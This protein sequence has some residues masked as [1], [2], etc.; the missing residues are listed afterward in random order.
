M[1]LLG[2]GAAAGHGVLSHDLALSGNLARMLS[3][4]MGRGV[5]IDVV[6]DIHLT[7]GSA[8]PA[9]QQIKLSRYDGIVLL[10]G[11]N[12]AMNLVSLRSWRRDMNALLSHLEH[13]GPVGL[14]VFV[15]TVPPLPRLR[16]M[17][18]LP[19]WL[20]NRHARRLND[21][22]ESICR[23]RPTTTLVQFRPTTT[24][25]PGRHRSPDTYR[26]WAREL[27]DPIAKVLIGAPGASYSEGVDEEARQRSLDRLGILDTAPEERFDRIAGL[28]QQLFGTASAAVTFIDGD[29]QWVKAQ[30]GETLDEVPRAIAFCDFTIRQGGAMVVPDATLDPRF[31]HN[32]LVNEAMQLRFY[33]GYP[34]EAPDGERVGA[35]CLLDSKPHD[36]SAED[37]ALLRTLAL[38]VQD[39]LWADQ[40]AHAPR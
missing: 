24:H 29:R 34:L 10:L 16:M 3:S 38:M 9:A 4:T 28:A 6:A 27:V 40:G 25:E 8:L 20:A 17:R 22:L 23:G 15:L 19:T 14:R 35:L 1:L 7:A 21:E 13:N 11:V 26:A 12:D 32:P 18:F 36:F 30:R 33:A 31:R 5:D 2:N 37:S 39:Q